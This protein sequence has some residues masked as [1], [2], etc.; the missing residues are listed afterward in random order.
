MTNLF[1]K[2]TAFVG[3][4][5][6]LGLGACAYASADDSG[7]KYKLNLADLPG[8]QTAL[9]GKPTAG[10]S[11]AGDA[12]ISV[13]FRDLWDHPNTFLGRRVIVK[14]RV[15]RIFRQG[16]VGSFPP[17]AEIWIISP[18]SDPF[19]VV[20]AQDDHTALE[21]GRPVRFTG[22][23]LK[24]V[25]YTASVGKRLA[26]LIVGKRP[27]PDEPESAPGDRSTSSH[28]NSGEVLQ[29]IG[30]HTVKSDQERWPRLGTNMVLA[31]TMAVVAAGIITWQHMRTPP[32]R[33]H[34]AR[35]R[36]DLPEREDPPLE[37]IN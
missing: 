24:M 28:E 2:T 13:R 4:V 17:L 26:P 12:P 20:F 16:A 15:E 3:F 34:L 9:D 11:D 1:T 30:G 22:T 29:A 18:S 31:L 27:P 5:A 37:F 23:F 21:V 25:S 10:N 8:Y 6:A 35:K 19:C 32:P 7:T 14:G 36:H 33:R